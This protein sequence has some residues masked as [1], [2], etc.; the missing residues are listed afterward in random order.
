[1]LNIVVTT[2]STATKGECSVALGLAALAQRNT[3][4][5]IN[6]L[7]THREDLPIPLLPGLDLID[8]GSTN[9]T[10]LYSA[11]SSLPR[12]N[13]P[14]NVGSSV[15]DPWRSSV[16]ST[17]GNGGYPPAPSLASPSHP[18]PELLRNPDPEATRKETYQ[19]F[20]NLDT[21]AISFAPEKEGILFFKHTNYIVESK[22]RQTTVIRRYSDFWWMHEVLA[23]RFPFRILPKLPPK[24]LG[25]DEAFLER[26][27]RGLIRFMNALVRHP[28]LRKDPLV[29]SFLTEPV[30]LAIWRKNVVISTEDEFTTRLSNSELLPRQISQSLEK[31]IESIKKR[32]PTS[33]E[34]YRSMVHVLDRVQKRTEASAADF[35]RYS[36]ALNALADCDKKCHIDECYS[37]GQL[38]DGYRKISSHFT[39]T[40]QLL[41]EQA[42][43]SQR[44][45]IEGLKRHRDLL[46]SVQEL[47]QRRDLSREGSIA[48]MMKKRIVSNEAKLKALK[49]S[50]ETAAN[51]ATADSSS[52]G[53]YDAQI[54][55]VTNNITSD[56]AELKILDQRAILQQ[57]TMWMEITYYHKCHTQIAG[58]YQAFVHDQMK[59]SQSQ[60]DNWK[61]LSSVVH[62][63]PMEVNGFN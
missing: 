32:V 18:A 55:K 16:I 57:H 56:R 48:E 34:Y 43:V 22:N 59:T 20:L 26:R 24:R 31:E 35:A 39:Q 28:V 15:A 46:V 36:L 30:E 10:D 44:E 29:V 19:W 61:A 27:L 38:S 60:H 49:T 2:R 14:V 11:S 54:E 52:A 23:K 53:L 21:I 3:D 33:I 25:A 4:I 8:F 51:A 42:R 40:S 17:K 7:I 1:I 5:T 62:E 47:M 45:M 12:V 58:M 9:E 6:N 50:A 63:L 13:H 37:C 41:D